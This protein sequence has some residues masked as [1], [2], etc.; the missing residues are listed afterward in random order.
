M[1]NIFT[2]IR[3][4]IKSSDLS[5]NKLSKKN[6]KLIAMLSINSNIMFFN[7]YSIIKEYND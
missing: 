2:Y 3:N 4:D 6:K 7:P 5:M 1:I